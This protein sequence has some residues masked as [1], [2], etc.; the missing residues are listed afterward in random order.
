MEA[1]QAKFERFDMNISPQFVP[2][3]DGRKLAYTEFGPRNGLPLF[4]FHGATSSRLEPQVLGEAVFV[5][6]NLRVIAAEAGYW[7]LGSPECQI[8]L[9]LAGRCSTAG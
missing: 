8:V 7:P 2:L 4:W 5:R 1:F 3:S 9:E 6:F